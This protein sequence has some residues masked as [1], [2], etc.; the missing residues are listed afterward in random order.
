[1]SKNRP[2]KNNDPYQQLLVENPGKGLNNLISNNLIDDKESPSLMNIKYVEAGAPSK[3]DGFTSALA[4]A[5]L[6]RGLGYFN[7]LPNSTKYL[8]TVVATTLTDVITNTTYGTVAFSGTGTIFMA[9]VAGSM[10]IWDG[11]NGGAQFASGGTL[12]RPGTMPKA[13]FSTYWNGVHVAAGVAGQESRLYVTGAPQLS[14]TTATISAFQFTNLL[15]VLGT[16]QGVPGATV[17]QGA[18]AQ[19]IDVQPNDSDQITGLSVF[20]NNLIVFKERSIYQ[21]SFDTS[22]NPILQMI[23]QA[24]GCVGFKTIQRVDNDV[25]FLTRN[26]VYVLGYEPNFLTIIRTNELSARIHPLIETINPTYFT[27][28]TSMFHQYVYYLGIPSGSSTN[29]LTLTYDRRYQSWSQLNHFQ[30]ESFCVFYDSNNNEFMYFTSATDAHVYYI[31]PNTYSANGSAITATY[32][33]KSYD[34]GNFN[35]F[36]RWVD[37]TIFFRQ[38]VGTV[39]VTFYTDNG[40][41]ANTFSINTSTAAGIGSDEIGAFAFGG[42]TTSAASDTSGSASNIPYRFRIGTKSR[43][44]QFSITNNATNQNFV[45]LGYAFRYRPYSSFT[46]PSSLKVYS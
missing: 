37:C 46:W 45:I 13:K 20:Q 14:T 39:T 34:L 15:G 29:N 7:D 38:L 31:T 1:M 8:L 11:V 30:P 9:E 22:G 3:T 10:A 12:T 27:T 5:T 41:I 2:T 44:I 19:Y 35:V 4:T 33:S 17:F 40:T 26:G 25:F 36:K 32:Y 42:S 6:A 18:G 24:Y 21:F 23:T 28:A 43:T 16:S